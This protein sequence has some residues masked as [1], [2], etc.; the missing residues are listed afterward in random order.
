MI[1]RR[2]DRPVYKQVADDLRRRIDTGEF[3]PDTALPSE[4]TLCEQYDGIS[5]T[6]V[7]QGLGILKHE[8][9]IYPRHGKGWFVRARPARRAISAARYQASLDHW[10]KPAEQHRPSAEPAP[11]L[12]ST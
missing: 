3:Q 10:E 6:L 7:R 9:V 5:R 1:N 8:G 12:A 2:S 11:G 4:P